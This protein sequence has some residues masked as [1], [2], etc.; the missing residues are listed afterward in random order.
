MLVHLAKHPAFIS[1]LAFLGTVV[2]LFTIYVSDGDPD[3]FH[4]D[5]E[6]TLGAKALYP[7]T[8][9]TIYLLVIKT[10]TYF[11]PTK[12][13]VKRDKSDTDFTANPPFVATFHS[14]NLFL[15]SF[16]MLIYTIIAALKRVE[17]DGGDFKSLV[18]SPR[19]V[20]TLWDGKL[21]YVTYIFYLS[22]YYELLDTVL[23]AVKG[24]EVIFLH[25]YHHCTMIFLTWSWFAF[26]WLE[27]AWWCCLVNSLI[28]T[29]MYYYY[30]LTTFKPNMN[31][32]WKKYITY[33]QIV[34]FM[35][36]NFF[37]GTFWYLTY[38]GN[39][40][41][42]DWHTSVASIVVNCSFVYL[43]AKFSKKKYSS[44]PKDAKRKKDE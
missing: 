15:L 5:H 32:W 37:V 14:T 8:A 13:S 41:G 30:L 9:L 43:F 7:V 11:I 42:G 21:G 2:Y 18:C 31:I 38:T 12:K 19:N 4:F 28:H 16:G 24:K 10:L 35:T 17:E 44:K 6:L 23:L 36:G 40:C 26:D 1:S 25:V 22:K 20:E 3:A 29:G 39:N 27:G 33:G 34:Q